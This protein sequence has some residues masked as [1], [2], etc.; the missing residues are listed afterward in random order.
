VP[1]EQGNNDEMKNRFISNYP[2]ILSSN[3][4]SR[5]TGHEPIASVC[6]RMPRISGYHHK[7]WIALD[8]KETGKIA[9]FRI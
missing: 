9:N 6:S 7:H 3:F 1:P 8:A 2:E 5:T 4:C